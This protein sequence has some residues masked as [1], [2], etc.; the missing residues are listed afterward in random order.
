MAFDQGSKSHDILSAR[1]LVQGI[2]QA[3][4]L[5]EFAYEGLRVL[6]LGEGV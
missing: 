5:V 2:A 6:G 3:G 4:F 1:S